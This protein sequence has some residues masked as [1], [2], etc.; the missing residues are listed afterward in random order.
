MLGLDR[1]CSGFERLF[2]VSI[3]FSKTEVNSIIKLRKQGVHIKK[4]GTAIEIESRYWGTWL[5]VG[6][7][8]TLLD[9]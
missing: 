4:L 5:G 8:K 2:F 3:R 6:D 1:G 7:E 9:C